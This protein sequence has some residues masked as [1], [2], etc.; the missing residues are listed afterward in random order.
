MKKFYLIVITCCIYLSCIGQ[1]ISFASYKTEYYQCKEEQWFKIS[2]WD[3]EYDFLFSFD[4]I[5]INNGMHRLKNNFF[6]YSIESKYINT[7]KD[8]VIFINDNKYFVISDSIIYSYY[9]DSGNHKVVNGLVV[10][11]YVK[12][13]EN[14]NKIT[15]CGVNYFNCNIEKYLYD[16][17]NKKY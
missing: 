7:D 3:V 9:Y 2:S 12:Y 14:K 16:F 4:S 1:V 11:P 8:I 13:D 15:G 5:D 6:I 10:D 17:Y